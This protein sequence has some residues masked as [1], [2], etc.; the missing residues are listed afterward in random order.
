MYSAVGFVLIILG[1]LFVFDAIIRNNTFPQIGNLI[2]T[3]ALV[4]IIIGILAIIVGVKR[5]QKRKKFNP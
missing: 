5:S 1:V 3:I 4:E 2:N